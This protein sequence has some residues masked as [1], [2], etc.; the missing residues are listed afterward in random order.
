VS[1]V[2]PVHQQPPFAAGSTPQAPAQ[3]RRRL[4]TLAAAALVVLTIPGFAT[5]ARAAENQP[6]P[7][8]KRL[9]IISTT[10]MVHDIVSRVAGDRG[11]VKA[12]MGAGV[13]PH[14]Y[15]PTRGDVQAILK[16]DMVFYS[17]LML[18]GRMGDALVKV[19]R[20]GK[21][22]HAVTEL[23]PDEYLLEPEGMPGHSDPH[24]WGDPK[25][26]ARCGQA[27]G[28][29]LAAY[30]PS[31]AELYNARARELTAELLLL[32]RY[33]REVIATIPR[34]NRIL[35]TAHDAFNYF[36]RAYGLEVMGIQ[37]ISTESEAGLAD[38]RKLVDLVCERKIP[39]VFV[40]TSVSDKNVRA[41]VE[42]AK[43]RGHEV[44]IGGEL[45]S[46][47]MGQEN[48]WEGTYPGMID[49]NA[50]TIARALRGKPPVG[51][52]REWRRT[53]PPVTPTAQADPATPAP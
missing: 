29:A 3:A 14:L 18:E 1:P 26:W 51:G 50:T 10:G 16:S 53:L 46:D 11:E 5:P 48:T 2:E 43:A 40:E 31:S 42:G 22:V 36:G 25:A 49:H 45:F 19:A 24:V 7:Q 35:V 30:D 52:F 17:G 44:T 27:V 4:L 6:A 23:I 12:L 9:Q 39:A 8:A 47:A 33:A 21:P 41:L 20:S 38:L 15:K 37:G 32:D 28:E 34:E 13:D